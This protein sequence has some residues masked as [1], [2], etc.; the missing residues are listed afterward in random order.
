VPGREFRFTLTWLWHYE[1]DADI[2]LTG[3]MPHV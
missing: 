1:P 2:A 3:S